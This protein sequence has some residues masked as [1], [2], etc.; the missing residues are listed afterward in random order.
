[1]E[2]V[3]N[4]GAGVKSTTTTGRTGIP[5]LDGGG[6]GGLFQVN[7]PPGRQTFKNAHAAKRT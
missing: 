7:P 3:A 5:L 4:I 6:V 1:M 2:R